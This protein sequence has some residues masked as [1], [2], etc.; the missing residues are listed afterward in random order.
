MPSILLTNF[1]SSSLLEI[2]QGVLPTGYSI[3]SLNEASKDEVIRK[4]PQADYLLVGGRTKIDSMVISAANRLKMIQRTGVGLDSIDFDALKGTSIPVY[5]NPGINSR[6][7]AEHTLMLILS[8]IR[9][10]NSVDSL[11]KSGVWKKHELGMQN[12]ELEGKTVGLIG[13][14]HIGSLVA[15]MLQPFGVRTLYHKRE[16]L[17]STAENE[18]NVEYASFDD[19]IKQSDIISLHCPLNPQTEDLLSWDEFTRMKKG[20]FIINTSRGKLIDE[21]ALVHNLKSGQL[22]GAGLDVFRTEPLSKESPLLDL[23]NVI[24]TP[25]I[26]GITYESFQKMM[27]EAFKNITAFELGELESIQDK[28]LI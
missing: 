26:S 19:L 4:I 25:H 28:K 13:L 5:V 21:D 6:S 3:I 1:Y 20:A 14:G 11:L 9:K 16:R 10:L 17:S 18:L 23:D 2:I 27:I 12:A 8:V 22:R 15:K 24:L 7:V